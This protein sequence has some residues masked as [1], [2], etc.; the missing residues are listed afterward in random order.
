MVFTNYA[1]GGILTAGSINQH[2]NTR[3]THVTRNGSTLA[4]AASGT[5]VTIK[6]EYIASGTLH[7]TMQIGV[8]SSFVCAGSPTSTIAIVAIG[9]SATSPTL[10]TIGSVPNIDVGQVALTPFMSSF[11]SIGS[12]TVD[13]AVPALVRFSR[14]CNQALS[15]VLYSYE[16]VGVKPV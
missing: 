10:T 13:G 5:N 8:F 4:T 3:F 15:G 1:D 9:G 14:V 11:F 6:D 16:I 12:T 2:W 7:P